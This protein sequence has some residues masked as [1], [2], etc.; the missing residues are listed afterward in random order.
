LPSA[1]PAADHDVSGAAPGN[2]HRRQEGTMSDQK[3]ARKRIKVRKIRAGK[4][5]LPP[6]QEG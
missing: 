1:S 2:T 5:I 3:I 6:H 4:A